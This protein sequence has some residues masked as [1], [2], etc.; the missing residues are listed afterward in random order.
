M[1]KRKVAVLGAT[2]TVGQRFIGL[3]Q[4]HP[5]FEIS[6]L[7]TSDAKAGKRYGDVTPWHWAGDMPAGVAGVTPQPTGAGPDAEICFSALPP[8]APEGWETA[9]AKTRHPRFSH[10]KNHPMEDDRPLPL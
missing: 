10:A 7:T 2:G 9:P 8:D 3:L 6:A 1:R 4:G 5:W